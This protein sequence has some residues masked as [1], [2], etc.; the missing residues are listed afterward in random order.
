MGIKY[1]CLNTLRTLW[2]KKVQLS[3]IGIIIFLSSFLYTTMFY[4]MDSM[5]LSI[6]QLAKDAN[7]EDFSVEV[8]NAIMPS[9][10]GQIPKEKQLAYS[11]YRLTDLKRVDYKLYEGLLKS[12]M[13]SFSKQYPEFDLEVRSYKDIDFTH[14]N[15]SHTIRIFKNAKGINLTYLEKGRLPKTSNEIVLTSIYADK[16]NL[17]LGDTITIGGKS[18][19]LTGCVLFSDMNLPMLGTDLIIDSSKITMGT[20]K[21]SAY[22]RLQGEEHFYFAGKARAEDAMANFKAR[23]EDDYK[24]HDT[25]KFITGIVA[26]E[27]QMRSG[28]IYEELRMGKAA[29]LGI[30]IVIASM[31][32]MI[33]GILVSKILR[34][35]KVQIG[36][37]KALGYSSA[38]VAL[39]YV[40]LLLI[41]GLPMLILGYI[42]GVLAAEPMKTFYLEFYLMPNN[43]I[44]THASVFFVAVLVPLTFILGVSFVMIRQMLA[45]ET[46]KLL[47]VSEKEKMTRVGK[48]I[49]KLL[50]RTKAQTKFKYTFIFKNM[51]KFIVFFWGIMFSTM[52]ILLSFM[53][54]GFFNKMT[55]DYYENVDYAYEGYLDPAKPKPK[56]KEAEEKFLTAPNAFYK[57]DLIQVKG[58]ELESRLHKLTDKKGLDLTPLLDQGFIVNQ[59]FAITYDIKLGDTLTLE[60]ADTTFEDKIVGISN[61]YGDATVYCEIEALS[62]VLTEGRSKKLFSGVYSIQPLDEKMYMT[63]VDKTVIMEQAAMMQGFIQMAMYGM[64][65]S[66]I[67]MSVL[68]LYVLTTLTVEDNYYNISLLKVM[69]YSKREVDRMILNSYLVYA[70]LTYVVSIPITWIGGQVMVKY[71]SKAFG[72]VMPLELELWHTIAGMFLVLMIFLLGTYA[73]KR[74]I[75]KVSLQEVLKAYRE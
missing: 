15:Q 3:C 73:A 44:E 11:T 21:D 5:T 53:M 36:V 31:A 2:K 17:A 32:V 4:T 6:E 23:V 35:E 37:L 12:R 54:T 71:F 25:L 45:K 20:L 13:K 67:F 33:V 56:M 66:A 38:E 41:V 46:I 61:N 16:N 52:L 19:T 30:S 27:N 65:G 74:H 57:E 51:G 39:P 14:N 7:Q 63:V 68:I 69:G 49:G 34:N 43:P 24:N 60:M 75:Q 40:I 10:L 28:M 62:K 29:T 9:E 18:Y 47:K 1:L 42:G 70:G 58:L 22:E 48:L 50:S 8:I 72:M 59:S 55:T 64:I 26:T